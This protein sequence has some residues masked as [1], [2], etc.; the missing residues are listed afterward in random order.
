MAH[1]SDRSPIP[2]I[3]FYCVSSRL[4]F[5]G[6]VGLINSLRLAGHSEPIYLLDCGLTEAQR[7]LLDAAGTNLLA[8][9]QGAEPWLAKTVA[10]LRHPAEVMIL[11]DADMVVTR[12]LTPLIDDAARGRVVAFRNHR[13]RFVPEW[14]QVLGVGPMRRQPYLCSGLVAMSRD[15]GEEILG[16]MRRLSDRVQIDLTYFE[17]HVDGYPLLYADQDVLNAILASRVDA[18]RIV[19]LD[20][21]LAPMPP[22][23]GLDVIDAPTLRCAFEDGSEPFV[24]HHSLSPKPWQRPAYDGVYSRLLRRLLAGP[25]VAIRPPRREV[26]LGLRVGT[27][28]SVERQ[29]VKARHRLRSRLGGLIR[30]RPGVGSR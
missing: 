19:A 30:G 25:D 2:P 9:P 23:A 14:E 22:F 4:Y 21:R 11:L 29:R 10:P 13:D 26:P 8:P 17:R 6:A 5:L 1:R 7:R 16:T 20:H 24:V 12:P 18:D 3:A 28:A 15:P 27:L